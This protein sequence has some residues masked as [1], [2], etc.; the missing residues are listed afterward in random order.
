M[1]KFMRQFKYLLALALMLGLGM[2]PLR[3]SMVVAGRLVGAAEHTAEGA[4]EHV[5][6]QVGEDAATRAARLA[7]QRALEKAPMQP[8]HVSSHLE[9]APK[10]AGPTNVAWPKKTEPVEPDV[11]QT[12]AT[13]A[14]AT[15]GE[16][17]A[18]PS[19]QTLKEQT[20]KEQ[21]LKKAEI[22]AAKVNKTYFA[23]AAKLQQE[24]QG[25]RFAQ[26]KLAWVLRGKN[27]SSIDRALNSVKSAEER[28]EDATIAEEEA[29]IPYIR[30]SRELDIARDEHTLSQA[31]DPEQ[32]AA[33]KEKIQD[34]KNDIMLAGSAKFE[35]ARLKTDRLNSQIFN[36]HADIID[37]TVSQEELID[38]I[39]EE[40]QDIN[41]IFEKRIAEKSKNLDKKQVMLKDH[42]AGAIT[43]KQKVAIGIVG[44]LGLVGA[45]VGIY[46]AT[47]Q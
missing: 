3:A 35:A 41:K 1:K 47:K 11:L 31:T 29:R 40:E 4:V 36:I 14:E 28:V 17:P 19:Q 15:P 30:Q 6:A 9:P 43:T 46:E 38:A 24:K 10:A 27:L 32:I 8:H 34:E 39:P 21:T 20:L 13:I 5:G 44:G 37:L 7:E 16:R 26:N 12:E 18:E 22:K 23:Q 42:L 25:L 2:V 45:G 33:L